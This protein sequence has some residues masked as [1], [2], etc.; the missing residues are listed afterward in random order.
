MSCYG[1]KNTCLINI[2]TQRRAPDLK[3]HFDATPDTADPFA[4]KK[5]LDRRLYHVG[6]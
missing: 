4:S 1:A 3:K 2:H 6:V 5:K